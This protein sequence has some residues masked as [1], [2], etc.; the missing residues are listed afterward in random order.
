MNKNNIKISVIIPFYTHENLLEK[1]LLALTK[2]TI[3]PFEVI[4]LYNGKGLNSKELVENFGFKWIN[5]EKSGSYTAR[6]TGIK[7]AKGNIIAF[8][9][10]DCI[11]KENWIEEA[12]KTFNN[13]KEIGIIGGK[14]KLIYKN[15]KPKTYEI[16][17]SLFD[18]DQ[19]YFIEINHSGCTSNLFIRKEVFEK[20]GL[21]DENFKSMGDYKFT[22][23]AY[24][25]GIPLYYEE[26]VEVSHPTRRSLYAF[27]QKQQRISGGVYLL[28]KKRSLN[29]FDLISKIFISNIMNFW[30]CFIITLNE[31]FHFLIKFKIFILIILISIS[32]TFEQLSIFLGK[33]LKN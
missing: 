13:K 22:T 4:A 3:Q 18:F 23:E 16:F 33:K 11:P 7:I 14:I 8:T 17:E 26:S 10:A 28:L 12:L 30:R 31:N 2:Q 19:K 5:E 6:N 1:C 21:F 20:N 32:N 29:E 9:D 24:N 27:I 15:Q 25:K